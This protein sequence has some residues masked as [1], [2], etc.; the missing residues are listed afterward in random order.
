V[1]CA[2]FFRLLLQ[3]VLTRKNDTRTAQRTLTLQR[4]LAAKRLQVLLGTLEDPHE[5]V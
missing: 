3:E 2:A 5:S 4:P 1:R